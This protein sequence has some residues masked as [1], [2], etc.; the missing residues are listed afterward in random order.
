M[1]FR[2]RR[3]SLIAI[4]IALGVFVVVSFI[5]LRWLE[6]SMAFH[7]VRYDG[8]PA[9]VL[10]A[11]AR[12]VWFKTEDGISLHGWLFESERRPPSATIIYFHGN[13]GNISNDGWV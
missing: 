2:F 1:S 8:G 4:P 5:G 10:P 11:R 7:P 13:G 3:A 12:D 9:W 6:N